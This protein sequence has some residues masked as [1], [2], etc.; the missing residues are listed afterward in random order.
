MKHPLFQ[1]L[2]LHK[3]NDHVNGSANYHPWT[4][5]SHKASHQ[6]CGVLS[7]CIITVCGIPRHLKGHKSLFSNA[8]TVHLTPYET[9]FSQFRTKCKISNTNN[10]DY[11]IR[12]SLLQC[13]L[14]KN[15]FIFL[16]ISGIISITK[17]L[18]YLNGSSF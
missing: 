18:S 3:Q 10:C 11:I 12:Q 16:Y 17:V 1:D 4:Q 14:A 6:L 15:L 13:M 9:L 2:F 7:S 5:P 8:P